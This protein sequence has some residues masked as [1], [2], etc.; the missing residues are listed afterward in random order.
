MK[1]Y[2]YI[3]SA[4]RK[5]ERTVEDWF[6]YETK[7]MSMEDAEELFNKLINSRDGS[8]VIV[9]E[10]DCAISIPKHHMEKAFIIKMPF[11]D[12]AS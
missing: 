8:V 1:Y 12:E 2:I 4:F 10:Y 11:T 7:K 3:G 6:F 5:Y 9:D